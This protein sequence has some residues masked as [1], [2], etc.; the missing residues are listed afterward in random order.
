M[1]ERT[2]RP[3][4]WRVPV[5]WAMVL[6][7]VPPLWRLVA[8]LGLIGLDGSLLALVGLYLVLIVTTARVTVSPAG[9]RL[10]RLMR[11]RAEYGWDEVAGF[12]GTSSFRPPTVRLRDGR[13]LAVLDTPGD[14]DRVVTALEEARRR[15]QAEA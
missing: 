13:E 9:V 6:V 4:W 2:I 7:A 5:F 8:G 10:H 12:A 14:T 11:Q 3:R 1:A 15:W